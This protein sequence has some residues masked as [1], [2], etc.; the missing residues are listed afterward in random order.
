MKFKANICTCENSFD[1]VLSVCQS[2]PGARILNEVIIQRGPKQFDVF[3]DVPGPKI[4]FDEYGLDM[5][6]GPENIIFSGDIMTIVLSG[7]EDI[8]VDISGLTKEEKKELQ[9]VAIE[10]FK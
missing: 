6:P 4:S 5:E 1:K 3:D 8:E 9:V 2:E 10:I 7:H